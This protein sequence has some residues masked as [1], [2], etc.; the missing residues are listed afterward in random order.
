MSK[1]KFIL[2][3][4]GL[5][6]ILSVPV[7]YATPDGTGNDI[8]VGNVG[9]GTM[10]PKGSLSVLSGNVGIGTW[11][12][13]ALL[14]VST[15]GGNPAFLAGTASQSAYIENNLEVDS[16]AYLVNATIGSLTLSTG[17]TM[18]GGS[19]LFNQIEVTGTSIFN[20]KGA[21]S[22]GIGTTM[23][24][25]SGA[26]FAVM[27]GNVGIGTVT[28]SGGLIV[29]NGNV[30]IG[31]WLP[32]GALVVNG[33]V[34]IGSSTPTY[35]L[36]VAPTSGVIA[37]KTVLF[38]DATPT[39]GSTNVVVK[40][41]A[42]DA[43]NN[44]FQITTSG[45][46][47]NFGVD[48]Y[49]DTV[50]SGS[51]QIG[52][53]L[54]SAV[55]TT[56]LTGIGGY[57]SYN[58]TS[59]E[60]K[61][62]S[63]AIVNGYGF[64]S[65]SGNATFDTL[66]I[67]FLVNQTG[68]ATGAS[69][70]LYVNPTLTSAVDYRA[71][72]TAGYTDNIFGTP[73]TTLEQVL[74]NAP[75]LAAASTTTV[76]NAATQVITGAPIAGTNVSITNPLALWVQSGKSTFGGNVGIGTTKPS[77]ALT[78]MNGNVGVGTW[79]PQALLDVSTGGGN[80][81]FLAGTASQSAY[82]QNN[83]EVDGTSY[84]VNATIGSLTLSTG[85]TM[86]GGT[87]LFNK[88]EVTGSSLFNT[89]G[90]ANV[91]IGTTM[92]GA[93]AGTALAVIG[94]NVGIGTTTPQGALV[95]TNGN[96]GIGTWLPKS[97]L[98]VNG[99]IN[100]TGVTGTAG[101]VNTTSTGIYSYNSSSRW[102]RFN[103][104]G[105]YNDF[106]SEGQPM[107]INWDGTQNVSFFGT[108]GGDVLIGNG[109][110]TGTA[111]LEIQGATADNTS[112]ALQIINSSSNVLMNVSDTGNVGI[113]TNTPQGAFVVTN[114]NVG[115][116]TWAPSALLNVNGAA[117][118][119]GPVT[120]AQNSGITWNG[121]NPG[122]N[123][124]T[125]TI[126]SVGSTNS[127]SLFVNTGAAPGGNYPTG[128]GIDGTTTG[129]SGLN[130]TVINLKAYSYQ[131]G[132]DSAA[133]SFWTSNGGSITERMRIDGNGN[134]GIGTWVPAKPFSVTGDSYNNGNIGIG[135]TFVGGVG[136]AALS[137]MNGNVGI[138][139]WAPGTSLTVVGTSSAA[140]PQ[141]IVG[142]ATT[143]GVSIAMG[144]YANNYG[145]LQ[146]FGSKP[147]YIN[148]LGNN[149]SIG[150]SNVV[151][152]G[153]G[154]TSFTV[155]GQTG[156][157]VMSGNVGIGTWKPQALLDVSTGGGNPAFLAGSAA[158][159]AYV[160]NNLEVDGTSYLVNATIGS[161]T[162]ATS[163]TMTGG[164]A[165]F[166]QIQVTGQ[167]LFNTVNG[168]VGIGT[169]MTGASAGT[170][171]AV[172]N[173]NVGIGTVAPSAL[174][175]ISKTQNGQTSLII[176]NRFTTSANTQTALVFNG[177]RDVIPSYPVGQIQVQSLPGALY[178]GELAQQGKMGFFTTNITGALVQN[179][180]IDNNGNVGI[181]TWVPYNKLDVN[182][183]VAIGTGYQGVQT[184]PA[185]GLLVQGNV[186][187]GTSVSNNKLEVKGGNV[188]MT[189]G[190]V[191]IGTLYPA[192]TLEVNGVI[193]AD[194]QYNYPGGH[195]FA[196]NNQFLYVPSELL[197]GSTS[198][199]EAGYCLTSSGAGGMVSWQ[200][201][202]GGGNVGV[203]TGSPSAPL[204]SV[205]FNDAGFFGGSHNFVTNGLNVGIGTYQLKNSLDVENV[206]IGTAFAG[207][208]LAPTW[209]LAVQGN[210]GIG[211]N[212]PGGD[213]GIAP[214]NTSDDA[215]VINRNSDAA[216]SGNFFRVRNA[217][218]T[219]DVFVM[220]PNGAN[221]NP[222][223]M[224]G[225]ITLTSSGGCCSTNGIT[226][227]GGANLL[228]NANSSNTGIILGSGSS[229]TSAAGGY[230]TLAVGPVNST[231]GF[232]PSSGT[233]TFADIQATPIITQTGTA[234]GVSR[235]IIVTPTITTAYD[236]RAFEVS[237]YTYNLL[238]TPPSTLQEVLYNA[239]TLAA[240]A[241]QTV[242]NAATQ[243]IT[244]APIAGTN[245]T[246]TNPSALWVQSG[247]SIFGGNVGIGTVS[248]RGAL[249]VL[250]GNVGLGT[251]VPQA[252]LDVSTGGGNPA[253]L[254]G[255]A[256]NS[257]YIQNNLEVD[258]TAYL[259]NATIG[260][261]TLSTGVSMTGGNAT[262][263]QIQV[264]GQS[265]FNTVNGT[266]GI[267]TTM[268]GASAGTKLA[269][270]GGNV[271]I[272]TTTP[273]GALVVTNG[274]VG[275]GTWT[276]SQPLFVAGNIYSTGTVGA[277]VSAANNTYYA[278]LNSTTVETN[279][280]GIT[281]FGNI[282]NNAGN[283]NSSIYQGG[284]A[285]DSAAYIKSTTANGTADFIELQV[286]NNGAT[287]AMHVNTT[288]NIGIGT[289]V[290]SSALSVGSNGVSIGT[291]Y[292]NGISAPTNGLAVLGNVGIG[293]STPKGALTVISGNVGIG[294]WKPQALL[295]V[296]SGGGNP[297]FLATP[298]NSAY[299]QNN[300]E[301][302][303][304]AYL[305]NATIGSL[306]L[307]TGITMTGGTS[308]FN[309]IQVTGQALLNTSS[310]NVGIGTTMTGA[311][312]NT[313]LAVMGG[314]VGIGT[315]TAAGA[316]TV[317]NGNVGIGTWAPSAAFQ[318]NNSTNSPFAVTSAGN[319][320]IG[321][322]TP[323]GALVVMGGNVG[324]GVTNPGFPLQVIGNTIMGPTAPTYIPA[325]PLNLVNSAASTLKTQLNIVNTGGGSGAG[326]AVDFYTY[327]VS[328]GTSPGLRM[329]ALDDNYSG[330]FTITTKTPGAATNALV[331][332][333]RITNVGNVGID[334][335]APVSALSILGNFGIAKTASDAYLTTTAP[336][337][338][339][340]VEGNVGIGTF[341]PFGGGLIVL[342]A[343][344]GN[345]GIGS[346]TPGQV[347]DVN[348]KIR[349]I[350]GGFTFPDGS[351]Q[352]TAATA[353]GLNYWNYTA[354]G[355][356]GISTTQAVGIG[357]TFIGGAGEASFA[358][359]NGNVGIGTWVPTRLLDI[360]TNVVSNANG[361]T[362]QLSLRGT[363]NSTNKLNVGYDTTSNFGFIEATNENTA[364][365]NLSLQ[366]AGGNV[367]IG[368]TAPAHP[369]EV[370]TT[371]TGAWIPVAG[372][373]APNNTSAGNASQMRF[374]V[375]NTT[376]NGAEWRFVYQGNNSTT[377]RID[378][379]WDGYATP[380]MSYTVGGN[381]GINVTGPKN[382]LDVNGS[383]GIGSYTGTNTA[384]TNGLIVS[385]NVGIGTF[386]PQTLLGIVGG[387]VGIGTWTAA[388]GSLI[389][390]T[391]NVGIG[392]AWP[393]TM[394]DVHGAIRSTTG[395]V[396]FPDGTTQTTAATAGGLNYWNYTASGNIGI[397]TIQAVGIGTTFIGGTGEASF[398][399]M[400]GNVG[401]GTWVPA[402]QLDIKGAGTSEF[403]VKNNW[404]TG[405]G[406]WL[407]L[408]TDGPS[409]IGSGGAGT[410]P[411]I[412]YVAGSAQWFSNVSVGDIA[413]R[414]TAGN[415][416]MGATGNYF[417]LQIS[418]TNSLEVNSSSSNTPYLTV[419][420]SSG[421]VGIGT[422]T[423]QGG[424]VVTN[425]NVGIGTW[426]PATAL[427]VNGDISF[428]VGATGNLYV[429]P[430]VTG[431][432]ND[433]NIHAGNITCFAANTK[434]TM[435]DGTLK[436]IQDIKIGN[437][438]K[439]YDVNKRQ[440]KNAKVIKIFH[441]SSKDV[442]DGYLILKIQ[443]GRILKVTPNHPIFVN[444]QWKEAGKLKLGDLLLQED[445]KKM[446]LVSIKKIKG[447]IPVY[448]LEVDEY[449]NYFAE[450]VL[451][452]N[453]A[454]NF[455]GNLYLS[456][457][458][459]N[460]A[461]NVYLNGAQG[462]NVGIGTVSAVSE[463]SINGS[464][465]GVAVA[466][467]AGD[468]Y[469]TTTAP[470][471]GMIVEGNVG[472]SS[473]NPGQALDVQGTVRDI[474]EVVGAGGI[475]LG[476]VNNTSWPTGGSNYWNYQATGNIGVST[477]Q[478]VGIGTTFIGGTGEA[479]FAVMNGNVGI[480]TWVPGEDL[481]VAANIII[482]HNSSFSSY[483]SV[484]THSPLLSLTTG[485]VVS[486][487]N[488]VVLG[489]AG[490][491][492]EMGDPAGAGIVMRTNGINTLD[493]YTGGADH[494]TFLAS[495]NV[496][497]GT[498]VPQEKLEIEGG[499]VGIGTTLAPNNGLT[500]MNGNVGIGTWVPAQLL[501]VANSNYIQGAIAPR[502]VT[503]SDATSITPN[504]NNA[505]ITY[506]SNSQGTGTLL[507]NADGGSPVNGQKWLLKIKS[508]NVQT[509]SW[510]GGYVGGTLALP[511]T[512]TGSG[513]IDYFAFIYDTI[514][515]KWDYTGTSAG[516]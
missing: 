237:T 319:V 116:G 286:G 479:S 236:F 390:A 109:L 200:P 285:T 219:A 441:H 341:N 394:L 481:D 464:I 168:N 283:N 54:S 351:T 13:Q 483:N 233:A 210:V 326:S 142:G 465:S 261:L 270:V 488:T 396:V 467:T 459:G 466:K 124:A 505:D 26:K 35:A 89:K 205:Q 48:L 376:G 91:G 301:V 338:G 497:I 167:S 243:I 132:G 318:V 12:P 146:S 208:K 196:D 515:S 31:T 56:T 405:T 220:G 278:W 169:T 429:A 425:G 329:A 342:P 271:G 298:A 451:V 52:G 244:G 83:L 324:I 134:L 94:G 251:W 371:A 334:V 179:L 145:W 130:D 139:T 289:T 163:V 349:S 138:G 331:E 44:I 312:A 204:N 165:S 294:T 6:L 510:T 79:M 263:N 166:N 191:G 64:N 358:V 470:S 372:F 409:G 77:G 66:A 213:L 434:I 228:L 133:L 238:G 249:S 388:G 306:T 248:P 198:P 267:G 500:V 399:V 400:N 240:A 348:G 366:P 418:P 370:S 511:T 414:N 41:G 320:G 443:N 305:V 456:G 504:S 446:R 122:I 187:I 311:S 22:V 222:Q 214:A 65:A 453:K 8:F 84:L 123:T 257:A 395:G 144:A 360:A 419:V 47:T 7:V 496:G 192:Q 51:L 193:I 468:S 137:V 147:L 387:N 490:N 444:S 151:E 495:G 280:N 36:T 454:G 442:S 449:H 508:K 181:G 304:T 328:G 171:L 250:S 435:S 340:I 507:I 97:A 433:L 70:G 75:T 1:N 141:L 485:S 15:G 71:I 149:I 253:L 59:G 424:L 42:N 393:G 55:A 310:G 95:V 162:L 106:E 262:F 247:T 494:V 423:P 81:A 239:P 353:G 50:L 218:N 313:K 113:G 398:A 5:S 411:W 125:L 21:G 180:T 315:T 489:N 408:S 246:I 303:G 37:G 436:N 53:T 126:G 176:E 493:F 325:S 330:D 407:N 375:S 308:S 206:S 428:P 128:F 426:V 445:G 498:N 209:G 322:T 314:N 463:L 382:F 104:N 344:T 27:G 362:S 177:F 11:K 203:G 421:N 259:V 373:F 254:A 355:N 185:N 431:T 437:M 502:V 170:A 258:G 76:T 19:S 452:H 101:A 103:T 473:T 29:M 117:T 403:S 215:I 10:T 277:S 392:S 410:N 302:D 189:G 383:M 357:T 359:M 406:V 4:F 486:G 361:T 343:N 460:L 287:K 440:V 514:N 499:G 114:G 73:P 332:R 119:T 265:I 174:L 72:E 458:I 207:Y 184:A 199:G 272:G 291:S 164:S 102:I 506:Q 384:P 58:A 195:V 327:D 60:Q 256:N 241:P 153:I 111:R 439:S 61:A 438:V 217:A 186:S 80:P 346:L 39:T 156:L 386:A 157:T 155:A 480:G 455:G 90:T 129:A 492:F 108:T 235:G 374:G 427:Q 24:G 17:L 136:E 513:K 227:N 335:A 450:G 377:N 25:A 178:A 201:C 230:Y 223:I 273:Q 105:S 118:I 354:A 234:T 356:I 268:T 292:T 284:G 420:N 225:N 295:D 430:I 100:I 482:A 365:Q 413:Y 293:T 40:A 20:T 484:G 18:T 299:V 49:G 173:G 266:V 172:T 462:R 112:N 216:F 307:S 282:D 501:T 161:L 337:G 140:S 401:I 336:S 264:T 3:I 131:Y 363:A 288:G 34:G 279:Y 159:S 333:F 402:A 202:G 46:T 150:G 415:I 245:V 296:S 152:V 221:Q 30:G 120:I 62:V 364:W 85:L 252:L 260:S 417:Q 69:R 188:V 88:I 397:S 475:T 28:P 432:A 14:D 474:G 127:A 476:G 57:G 160:Q 275:I 158:N 232:A 471:G 224:M 297:A 33:N 380:V 211:T 143:S 339:M 379:G 98:E 175:H 290:P 38:Q 404:N 182:G 82:V 154:T 422:T 347:L 242:T 190:N 16:T 68:T 23:T 135:T 447:Q 391:G 45:G 226:S 381:V 110:I 148:S 229:Y 2:F 317:M 99:Q 121:F 255:T 491:G 93:S 107:V 281:T 367:G 87:S 369:L 300:L 461:G 32:N 385:G 92:T 345:V 368:V 503:A 9:I 74:F 212:V 43:Y 269:V 457:G 316:L 509:F 516:F 274:N 96:V 389:V 512:T 378:F 323:S 78:I 231:N 183:A 412:A 416:D 309:Q 478:A 67:N 115:I 197:D 477:T 350:S 194:T 321:T 86:T 469:L 276:P 63:I 448:N 487:N 352:T 472:I